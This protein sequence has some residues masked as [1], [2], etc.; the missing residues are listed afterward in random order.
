M[1]G[2]RKIESLEEALERPFCYYCERDF[3][4]NGVLVQHQRAKHYKCR[5]CHKNLNTANGL[6]VHVANVHKETITEIQ[7]TLPGRESTKLEIFG[8]LG[9][10]E[11]F[12]QKKR[13][14]IIDVFTKDAADK[15]RK[16]GNPPKGSAEAKAMGEKAKQPKV[17]E[18]KEELHA[19]LEAHKAKRRAEKFDREAKKLW[20]VP[21]E[22]PAD[23]SGD[24]MVR[25]PKFMLLHSPSLTITFRLLI[26]RSPSRGFQERPRLVCHYSAR[27]NARTYRHIG[28]RHRL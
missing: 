25:L 13:Q 6:C 2:K 14:E 18:T 8:M 19:R 20:E 16:T 10:P 4:D 5:I 9:V 22:A 23:N 7:N 12:L 11:E 17:K 24:G 3:D 27:T 1:V 15:K 21:A 26:R 28:T